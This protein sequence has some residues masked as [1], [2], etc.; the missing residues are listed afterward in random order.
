[1]SRVTTEIILS[2]KMPSYG[3]K[4]YWEKRYRDAGANAT[5]DWLESYY[6]LTGLLASFLTNKKMRI[7]VLGCGNAK[8][9]ESLYDDGYTNVLNID[10]SPIVID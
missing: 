4:E 1:M 8:F 6:S 3:E 5:F 9:S 7:L 10:I 2:H